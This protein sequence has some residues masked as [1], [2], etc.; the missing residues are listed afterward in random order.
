MNFVG[1]D[2]ADPVGT[3]L[4]GHHRDPPPQAVEFAAVVWPVIIDGA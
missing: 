3:C 2:D 1:E 4:L